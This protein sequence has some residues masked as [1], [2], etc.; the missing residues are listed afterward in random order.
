MHAGRDRG[1]WCQ[2]LFAS[3]GADAVLLDAVTLTPA[4]D[5]E[6]EVPS[7]CPISLLFVPQAELTDPGT[8]QV[9]TT[10]QRWADALR[11]FHYELDEDGDGV[12]YVLRAG[13][14]E[15]VLAAS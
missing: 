13:H 1:I 15:V 12:R 2:L 6:G 14:E 3:G 11:I 10:L 4:S 5:A 9:L 8:R 7:G